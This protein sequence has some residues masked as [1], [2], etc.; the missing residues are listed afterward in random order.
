[1]ISVMGKVA[2][3]AGAVSGAVFAMKRVFDFAEEGAQLRFI[4]QR[5][6]RLSASIGTSSQVLKS[7]LKLAARGTISE[8]ELLA[9]ANDLVGLG[10]ANTHDEAVRL[11]RVAASLNMNMNQLVLTLTNKTTMRFDA[12]GVSVAGFEDRLKNLKATGMDVDAAF[13]EA[14]LQQAE[15]QIERVG[16]AADSAVAPFLR[17][18]AAIADEGDS[19]KK[20]VSQGLGPLIDGLADVITYQEVLTEATKKGI[21]TREQAT[22]MSKEA[23]FGEATLKDI[24]QILTEAIRA[25]NE[26]LLAGDEGKRLFIQRTREMKAATAELTT[27]LGAVKTQLADLNLA[28]QDPLGN[29]KEQFQESQYSLIESA[30]RLR[31]AIADIEGRPVTAEGRAELQAL[32]MEFANTKQAILDNAAAHEYE[33]RVALFGILQQRLAQMELTAD[34]QQAAFTMLNDIA[35]AWG[36]IGQDTFRALSAIDAAL[37]Q[38]AQGNVKAAQQEILNIGRA[39]LAIQGDYYVRIHIQTF[40]ETMFTSPGVRSRFDTRIAGMAGANINSMINNMFPPGTFS[41]GVFG[42]GGGLGSAKKPKLE[43]PKRDPTREA[44]DLA[45]ALAA[46][47]STAA[48][49]FRERTIDP[50]R[51]QMKLIDD[52][53]SPWHAD[54]MARERSAELEE[55]RARAAEQVAEAERKVLEFQKAQQRLHFLEQQVRLLDLI[56]EQK[57]NA[58]DILGDLQLGI[59]AD[60]GAVLAAM[61]RAIEA[62]IAQTEA[63]LG[64][65]SPSK[66]FMGFGAQIV[67]GLARGMTMNSALL[68]RSMNNMFGMILPTG[69]VVG[70]GYDDRRGEQYQGGPIIFR[71]PVNIRDDS[72]IDKLARKIAQEQAQRMH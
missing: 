19:A 8:M 72:D 10:L 64:I 3:A 12:L 1:M 50:L 11:V 14:F 25:Y 18:K 36:I 69:L 29:L 63:R 53:L 54:L 30:A 13:R 22:A 59:N 38:F 7:D 33:T 58:R 66:V 37:G 5:F 16:E 44:L 61:T 2:L 70:R 57:L 55:Q 24:I 46:I 31:D 47:G 20:S 41:A 35:L 68:D 45:N 71:G 40:Q 17:L 43:K 4:E 60:M 26:E 28:V 15:A 67:A 62:L 49:L 39:A 23:Y 21:V 51:E 56:R 34:Q 27:G 32:Q 52:L 6:D 9:R 48:D 65:G 42:G